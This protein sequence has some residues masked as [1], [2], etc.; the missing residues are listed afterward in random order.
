MAELPVKLKEFEL[1]PPIII[2]MVILGL[3]FGLIGK[4]RLFLI[5][6]IIAAILGSI[7]MYDF[8]QWEYEYGHNLNPKAA[9]KMPGQAYQPPLVGS[10]KILT[11]TASS[12]PAS[13]GYIM[14][15]GIFLSL[16]AYYVATKKEES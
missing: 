14:F 10:K 6:F 1:F 7:G 11:I 9:L 5:W 16:A 3:I 15:C 4:K 8:Y 13:G 12:Y 2:G